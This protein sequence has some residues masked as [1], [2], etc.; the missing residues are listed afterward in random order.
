MIERIKIKG[1]KKEHCHILQCFPSH[2]KSPHD[3]Y[4]C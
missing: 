4:F 3:L 1:P 2:A